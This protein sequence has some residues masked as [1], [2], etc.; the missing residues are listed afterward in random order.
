MKKSHFTII[1]L[2][3]VISIAGVMLSVAVPAFSRMIKG[4]ASGIAV[5]ELM[6]KINAARSYAI[7]NGTYVALV[8]PGASETSDF[9]KRFGNR[10]YR[11]CEV[12]P[13]GTG[14]RFLRWIPGEN[15][16]YFPNGIL[17]GYGTA[18]EGPVKAKNDDETTQEGT[19]NNIHTTDL[20][21]CNIGGRSYS[22]SGTT[23]NIANYLV[24]RPDGMTDQFPNPILLRLRDGKVDENG[25]PTDVSS[26][27]YP[28]VVRF[29]G[30]P[31]AYNELKEE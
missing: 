10:A 25:T 7:S 29:N 21:S 2:L 5:R 1:E 15:W 22:E 4:S 8:F 27:Y 9:Q 12:T 14:Y 28:L 6:G 11:V 13:N 3:L 30:K 23:K 20:A 26:G 16:Q 17:F 24:F 31:R 18:V 19:S